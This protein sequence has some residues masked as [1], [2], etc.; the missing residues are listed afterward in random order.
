MVGSVGL[1]K[2]NKCAPFTPFTILDSPCLHIHDS[3]V[4]LVV[5]KLVTD[6]RL[7]D[8]GTSPDHAATS[9]GKQQRSSIAAEV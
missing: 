3:R 4:L 1:A 8:K 5:N 2:R 7:L 6:I 9:T